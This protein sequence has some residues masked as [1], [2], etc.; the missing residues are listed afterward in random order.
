MVRNQ[1]HAGARLLGEDLLAGLDVGGS[2]IL[3]DWGELEVGAADVQEVEQRGRV[4]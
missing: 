2:E 4:H 1:G 3:A